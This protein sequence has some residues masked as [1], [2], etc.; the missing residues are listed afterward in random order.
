MRE[1]TTTVQFDRVRDCPHWCEGDC[2]HPE[3]PHFCN[4]DEISFPPNNCPCE[5]V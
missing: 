3:G 1:T 5:E 4:L 2:I